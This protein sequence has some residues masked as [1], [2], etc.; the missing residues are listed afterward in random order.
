MKPIFCGC[1]NPLFET[2]GRVMRPDEPGPYTLV[3]DRCK[4]CGKTRYVRLALP[5]GVRVK[6]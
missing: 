1:G 2:T 5:D 4:S 3:A 6:A